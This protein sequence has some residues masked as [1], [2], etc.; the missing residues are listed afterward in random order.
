MRTDTFTIRFY[1]DEA[2]KEFWEKYSA[3]MHHDADR[4]E[5]FMT[6]AG[7]G[8]KFDECDNYEKLL[9]LLWTTLKGADTF[10]TCPHKSKV[11]DIVSAIVDRG[12]AT[13]K[14]LDKFGGP[15]ELDRLERLIR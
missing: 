5:F 2:F 13:N 8:N 11:L 4:S 15:E 10:E 7:I 3:S 12:E 14:A 6:N 1:K 9:N